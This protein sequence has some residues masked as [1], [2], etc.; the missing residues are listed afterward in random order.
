MKQAVLERSSEYP[1]TN[2]AYDIISILYEKSKALEI[3]QKYMGDMR[4]DTQLRQILLEIHNDDRHHVERLKAHL[5][6]ILLT[7]QATRAVKR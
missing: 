2:A 7:E 4:H 5:A 1:L 3:Y 6:R